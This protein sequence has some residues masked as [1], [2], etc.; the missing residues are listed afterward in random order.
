M[1]LTIVIYLIGLLS[2]AG[3]ALADVHRDDNL[4]YKTYSII[5]Y[6]AG[7]FFTVAF[8]LNIYFYYYG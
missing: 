5:G 6:A 8:C 3:M 7:C 1:G 4:V 2:F